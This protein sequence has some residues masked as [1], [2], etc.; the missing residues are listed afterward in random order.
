MI[1]RHNTVNGSPSLQ[2]VTK[3]GDYEA[4]KSAVQVLRYAF[5]GGAK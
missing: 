5:N 3:A 2:R 4:Q 1:G